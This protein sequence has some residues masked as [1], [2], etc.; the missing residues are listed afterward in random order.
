M[1]NTIYIQK[2]IFTRLDLDSINIVLFNLLYLLFSNMNAF[3]LVYLIIT[4]F[5]SSILL[6]FNL[7]YINTLGSI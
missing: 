2:L 5:F 4:N 3:A 6:S 7:L 1:L